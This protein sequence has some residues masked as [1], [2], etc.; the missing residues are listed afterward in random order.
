MGSYRLI[1]EALFPDPDIDVHQDRLKIVKKSR[2]RVMYL[3]IKKKRDNN[4]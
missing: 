3:Y 4:P 2:A 1:L